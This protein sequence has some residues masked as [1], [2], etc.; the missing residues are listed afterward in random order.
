MKSPAPFLV[1]ALTAATLLLPHTSHALFFSASRAIRSAD[2]QL[3]K[4]IQAETEGR[5]EDAVN[6]YSEALN[7]YADVR[8]DHPNTK[9]DHV[10]AKMA[11][12]RNRMLGLFSAAEASQEAAEAQRDATLAALPSDPIEPSELPR[13]QVHRPHT[14][15][16]RGTVP[17]HASASSAAS[18]TSS[19]ALPPSNASLEQRI[20]FYLHANRS[21][22]AILELD[23]LIGPSPETAPYIQRLLLGRAL[24][25]SGNYPRAI[26]ILT[27]LVQ[28]HPRDPAVLSLAA[29][30]QLAHGNTFSAMQLLDTLVAAY[31]AYADAYVNLAYTRFAM[32]PSANRD[33]AIIYYKHALQFGATR[34]PNLEDELGL[35]ITAANP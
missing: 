19:H 4:A 20:D 24:V 21:A 31:P 8:K 17:S 27:P 7:A 34:D 12:C 35:K 11:E 13:N 28:E 5:R 18:P 14:P 3:E 6:A 33:E 1:V 29:G 2:A 16:L 9:P 10:T 30:A 26:S 32:N 23:T 22:E 25:A 15:T